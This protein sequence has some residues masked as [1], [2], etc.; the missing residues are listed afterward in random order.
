[1]HHSPSLPCRHLV[2]VISSCPPAPVNSGLPMAKGQVRCLLVDMDM[3]SQGHQRGYHTKPRGTRLPSVS[4]PASGH[5]AFKEHF[6]YPHLHQD[7]E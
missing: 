6:T 2:G 5:L 1:M 4:K 3:N 7:L